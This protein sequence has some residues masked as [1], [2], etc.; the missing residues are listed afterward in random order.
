[1]L[2]ILNS[3]ADVGVK[4]KPRD[5]LQTDAVCEHARSLTLCCHYSL[6]IT[7]LCYITR[8]D[9]SPSPLPILL[10]CLRVIR[11]LEFYSVCRS[12]PL[13]HS[14]YLTVAVVVPDLCH[15]YIFAYVSTSIVRSTRSRQEPAMYRFPYRVHTQI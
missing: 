3:T 12:Q 7:S 13:V 6:S 9:K 1:M 2:A 4:P 5:I 8:S 14:E 15:G 10:D 11:N